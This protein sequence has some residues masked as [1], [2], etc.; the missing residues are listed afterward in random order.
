MARIFGIIWNYF[1][2]FFFDFKIIVVYE[3]INNITTYPLKNKWGARGTSFILNNT[4]MIFTHLTVT[5][6]GD[7]TYV[8]VTTDTLEEY[9]LAVSVDGEYLEHEAAIAAIK[10]AGKPCLEQ[11]V[12]RD[13]KDKSRKFASLNLNTKAFDW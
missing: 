12:L 6:V 2:Y 10:E 8:N 4:I 1:F 13:T 11:I 7:K 3:Q 9:G 5:A